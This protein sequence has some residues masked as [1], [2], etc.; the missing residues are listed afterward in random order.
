MKM[1]VRLYAYNRNESYYKA[2]S[3]FFCCQKE[4]EDYRN[5]KDKITGCYIYDY[6]GN[7]NGV[8][9]GGIQYFN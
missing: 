1:V 2:K 9:D 7:R 4:M 3:H 5:A 8:C 6:D